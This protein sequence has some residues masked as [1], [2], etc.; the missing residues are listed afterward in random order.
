MFLVDLLGAALTVV[1]IGLLALGG[2]LAALLLDGE[3][4]DAL[5]LAIASVVLSTAQA[6]AIGLALGAFGILR[7]PIALAVQGAL[8][9]ALVYALRRWHAVDDP[10]A[11]LPALARRAWEMLCRNA[12]LGLI[13][14]HAVGSEALRG[15]FRPPLSWDAMTYHLLLTATWLQEGNLFPVLGNAPVNYYGYVP[16]NG[17]VWF[18]WWMA[19]SHSELWVNLAS[20]PHWLLLGLATGGVARELGAKRHWPI[21]AFVV[22]VLPT[23]VRF[24]ATEYVD[25]FLSSVC[26]AAC[27]FALRWLRQATT[28]EALLAGTALGLAAGAKVLGVAYALA[29]VGAVVV[30]ARGQWP[31]RSR[32]LAAGLL[33]ATALGGYFYLRNIALGV[34][35]LAGAC[36]VTATGPEADSAPFF[37]RKDSVLALSDEMFLHGK[38]AEV[39]LGTTRP[40]SLE[41]AIG[42]PALALLGLA[43]FLPFGLG[44]DRRRAGA[45]VAAQIWAQAV[46]WLAVPYAAQNH[47]FANVRYL[48]PAIALICAGSVAMAEVRGVAERWIVTIGVVFA[49]Q[50][51]LQLHAELPFQVRVLLAL[52]DA[53]LVAFAMSPTMRATVAARPARIAGVALLGALACVPWLASFRAADRTRALATEFTAHATRAGVL[54]RGWGWLADNGATGTVAAVGSPGSYF[55]YPAM[56]THLERRVRYVNINRANL[57]LAGSY[58]LCQPRVDPDAAAWLENLGKAGADWLLVTRFPNAPFAV[59]D[60][61]A[62][63]R[64]DRFT[65]R[66]EDEAT[67]VYEVLGRSSEPPSAAH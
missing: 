41:L 15:L 23:V 35:P 8:V 24:A 63:A 27:F 3:Q 50:G 5:H 37:A 57:S 19:P 21:A 17:S 6:V 2:Y 55:F 18:W 53:L 39:F 33:C 52:L 28:S 22:L 60:E 66:Y 54:A 25:L 10:L 30:L 40:P 38:L 64:P 32:Q 43:M 31:R 16:A 44:R 65:L 11:G 29:A 26:V 7:L 45:F 42:P 49:L 20:L 56:G 34:E 59:E 67:H 46:F 62:A 36:G 47:V 14:A 51:M 48:V 61:W 13:S 1:A 9:V 12:A 58:P 4:R